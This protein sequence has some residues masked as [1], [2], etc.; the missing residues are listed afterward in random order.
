M[1]VFA[2][3]GCLRPDRLRSTHADV[4]DLARRVGS[5]NVLVETHHGFAPVP[6]LVDLCAQTGTRILLDTLGLARIAEDPITAAEELSPW[7]SHAQVKGFDW[8]DPQAARHLPLESSCATPTHEL[9]AAA[10]SLHAVTVESK[11]GALAADVALLR[12]WYPAAPITPEGK[13]Q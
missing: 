2:A 12:G 6:E 4:A 11:A 10:A 3:I 13:V 9:L 7:I 1:K 5:G 8:R